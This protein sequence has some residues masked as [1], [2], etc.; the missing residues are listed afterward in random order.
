MLFQI[1]PVFT[2]WRAPTQEKREE[3]LAKWQKEELRQ[4]ENHLAG[5]GKP[6]F[7]GEFF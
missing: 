3:E 1:T 6:F 4:L 5:T 7:G 2:V